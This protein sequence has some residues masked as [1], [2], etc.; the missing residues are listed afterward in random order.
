ML[1]LD[2]N[3]VFYRLRERYIVAE[4]AILTMMIKCNVMDVVSFVCDVFFV[5]ILFEICVVVVVLK[6]MVIMN[7]NA[8][9][10]W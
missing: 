5:L 7:A 4:I 9:V 10:V 2:V 8:F 3:V 1:W 6:L